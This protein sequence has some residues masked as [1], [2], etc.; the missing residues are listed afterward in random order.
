MKFIEKEGLTYDD[1]LLVPQ[2]SSIR[3]R[4][5]VD[6]RTK[7][8][9]N[10]SLNL[11]FISSNVDTV[12]GATMAIIMA[13]L[14][15]IGIIHRFMN[16][17]RQAQK[18]T[19]VKRSEGFILGSPLVIG[20]DQTR[21]EAIVLMKEHQVTSLIVTD[22]KGKVLGI[23]TER[24]MWFENNNTLKISEIMTPY[25]KLITAPSNIS[26]DQARRIFKKNKIEKLPLVGKDRILKG[27][28]TS[29]TVLNKDRFPNAT[30][31]THG[32]LRVGA[33]TGVVGDYMER[34][35]ELIK[36]GVDVLVVD[37][38]HVFSKHGL[39]AVKKLRNKFP[40][41]DLIGGNIATPDAARALISIG[42][43]GLKVGIGP[44]GICITRM[45]AGAGV[46]QLTAVM[47]CAS[48]GFRNNVPVIADGGTNYPGDMTKALAAGASTVML[49][50]WLAGT[51]E[52][53]G[54]IIL[55]NNKKYKVHRGAASFSAVAARK[56][57]GLTPN[58]SKDLVEQ[59]L[60]KELESVVAEGV[61]TFVPYKGGAKD[62]ITQLT[63]ALRSGMSYS[64]AKTIKEL[65]KNSVFMKI[66]PAAFRESKA[67]NVQEI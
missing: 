44:G 54:S 65:W 67:H 50:G 16:I 56:T 9:K 29:R 25:E 38:A 49:T 33:A 12:T 28:I 30:V 43:D 48:V 5:D 17:E 8:S 7:L 32:R 24:D 51:D 60:D 27:L 61:E 10:I 36:S 42:C 66:S 11:P 57:Q 41:I 15:G 6:L 18:V 46:P 14:G 4:R 31:D 22:E 26:I 34:A 2:K 55:R 37:I 62:V 47:Q 45:V 40:K 23:V 19:R 3:S 20:P 1:V 35:E 53:P 21:G 58:T 64:N 13:K 39:T 63:G 59:E 52:S